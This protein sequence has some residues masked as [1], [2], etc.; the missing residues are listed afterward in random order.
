M[1]KISLVHNEP[2]NFA[3]MTAELSVYI[4]VIGAL[5]SKYSA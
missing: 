4:I 2:R 3:N 5:H 1:T